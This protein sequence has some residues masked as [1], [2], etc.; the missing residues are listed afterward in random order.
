M[1]LPVVLLGVA[2]AALFVLSKKKG[3]ASSSGEPSSWGKRPVAVIGD[4]LAVGL[5]EPMRKLATSA[6]LGF[7]SDATGGA[8]VGAFPPSRLAAVPTGSLVFVSLGGNDRQATWRAGELAAQAKALVATLA[9]K[10]C[11]V[12]WLNMPFPTLPDTTHTVEAWRASGAAEAD[13]GSAADWQPY[14][15]PDGV[16]LTPEGYQVLAEG[17]W[18]QSGHPAAAKP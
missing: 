5:V 9:N 3:A 14:R 17:L 2:A 6:G 7:Y 8:G 4:S 11:A 15:A 13:L 12:T 10:G 18:Q 16:H 1:S